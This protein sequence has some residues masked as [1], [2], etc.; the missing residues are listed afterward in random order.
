MSA[1]EARAVID[2]AS[3]TPPEP[4]FWKPSLT[5]SDRM[6]IDRIEAVRTLRST[7]F[8][9]ELLR[10]DVSLAEGKVSAVRAQVECAFR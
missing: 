3:I 9:N 2:A 10:I 7:A 6:S 1:A 5:R 4:W 8:G